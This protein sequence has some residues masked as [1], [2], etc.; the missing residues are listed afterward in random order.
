MYMQSKRF[1]NLDSSLEFLSLFETS[2]DEVAALPNPRIIKTHMPFNLLNPDLLNTCKVYKCS[3]RIVVNCHSVTYFPFFPTIFQVVY[4]A[5][6]PKDVIVSVFPLRLSYF[7][8][9]LYFI[10]TL[11]YIFSIIITTN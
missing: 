6:N 10:L 9:G 11:N 4:V 1:Q 5:R 7:L 3:T 2:L 8:I